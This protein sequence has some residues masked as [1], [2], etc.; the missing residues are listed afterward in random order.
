MGDLKQRLNEFLDEQENI[1]DEQ[2]K[3]TDEQ[4]AN[5]ALRKIKQL[6]EQQRETNALAEAEIEKINAWAESENEKAQR[7]IDYFQGLLA[8]YAMEQK[9]KN[10]KFKSMKLPN[11]AIRFRKQQPKFH[12]DD[13][14]LL[15]SLKRTGKTD[16]IKVKEVPDKAAVKKAFI[17]HEDKLVD[18]DTGEFIE[19][20]T[21]EHREDKFEVVTD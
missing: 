2:F 20:V 15:E 19:G 8:A 7:S 12:Y 21:V 18:P 6:Q 1:N 17:L 9:Q 3:I 10:P 16:F 5:W 13:E 11:G 4:Q 14:K